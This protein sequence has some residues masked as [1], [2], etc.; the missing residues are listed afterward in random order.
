MGVRIP[1]S[2]QRKRTI[3]LSEFTQASKSLI[4]SLNKVPAATCWDYAEIPH[5]PQSAELGKPSD[6]Q[7]K[8]EN[9]SGNTRF[10]W[11]ISG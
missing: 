9:N 11:V 1:H 6:W 5:S 10:E 8:Q 4:F 7:K 2:P 3:C